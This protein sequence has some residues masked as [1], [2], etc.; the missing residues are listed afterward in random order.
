MTTTNAITTGSKVLVLAGCRARDI[1]KGQG[2]R[3]ILV[4]P[5]EDHAQKVVLEIIPTGRRV[6]F[7]ARHANRLAD[8]QV[9]LNDGDPTHRITVKKIPDGEL[10]PGECRV[11][12]RPV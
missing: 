8:A 12:R 4:E 10:A 5:R 11:V 7:F 1:T 3:V 2:A 6:V 9:H